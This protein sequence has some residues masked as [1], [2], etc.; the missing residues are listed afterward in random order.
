V[1][2]LVNYFQDIGADEQK[3]IEICAPFIQGYADSDSYDTPEKRLE[4]FDKIW[5]Y[6]LGQFG[7]Y[8]NCERAKGLRMP[9]AAYNC[10]RCLGDF[11]EEKADI[12]AGDCFLETLTE[13]DDEAQDYEWLIEKLVPKG[14]PMIIGGKGGTGKTTMAL[15]FAMRILEADPEA[16]AVCICAEGTV[17]DTKVKA[18][19]MGLHDTGGRFHFLKR[20]DGGYAFKLSVPAELKTVAKAL[21]AAKETGKRIDFVLIDSIR[22]MQKGSLND[23]AVGE[24]MMAVNDRLCTILDATVC[25]VHH[26]KKNTKEIDVMDAFL[27]SVYTVTNVRHA[28][29]IK[30]KTNTARTVEVAKTNLGFE[31]VMFSA[32]LNDDRVRTAELGTVDEDGDDPVDDT[33]LD[34]ADHILLA[35]LGQGEPALARNVFQAGEFSGISGETLKRAK[36]VYVIKS[37]QVGRSWHWQMALDD[38]GN[39]LLRADLR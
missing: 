5:N 19:K 29:F 37:Y 33:Q 21:Q 26:S 12:P 20:Q 4:H 1:T 23:D 9:A 3:A 6:M 35:H 7:Y 10:I 27:G 38:N 11:K 39:P 36:K 24:T 13:D 8:F 32:M 25:Y 18:R 34:K 2:L 16:E 30:K 17:R 28:L 31:G 15:E 14:E 22:G